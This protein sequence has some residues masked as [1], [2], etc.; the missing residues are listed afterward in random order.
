[1]QKG[2]AGQAP[3]KRDALRRI[4]RTARR[5]GRLEARFEL[6]ADHVAA[7]EHEVHDHDARLTRLERPAHR[8]AHQTRHR[9]R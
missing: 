5:V 9:V 2:H 4:Q 3:S 7:V 1:M 6:V 8:R